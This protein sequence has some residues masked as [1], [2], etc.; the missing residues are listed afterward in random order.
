VRAPIYAG[1]KARHRTW[2]ILAILWSAICLAALIP[3]VMKPPGAS[4]GDDAVWILVCTV[5]WVRAMAT[6]FVIRG[7]YDR[8]TSPLRAAIEACEIRLQERRQAQ[9]TARKNPSLAREIG[10]GRPGKP[11]ALDVGLVDVNN[12]PN[13]RRTRPSAAYNDGAHRRSSG[14]AS[15]SSISRG[16]VHGV[17]PASRQQPSFG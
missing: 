2:I 6:S 15:L 10:I 1:V 12:A 14:G 4:G 9:L 7:A 8:M 3:I 13:R 17:T 5:G 11:G 16:P